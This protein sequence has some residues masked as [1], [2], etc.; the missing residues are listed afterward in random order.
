MYLRT[1]FLRQQRPQQSAHHLVQG[2]SPCFIPSS[3]NNTLMTEGSR[4]QSTA[5]LCFSPFTL[6]VWPL[7]VLHLKSAILQRTQALL[8]PHQFQQMML[9][10]QNQAIYRH[11]LYPSMSLDSSQSNL[12][13]GYGA[14]G[15]SS[16]EGYQ[17]WVPQVSPSHKN[18]FICFCQG[19]CSAT[20]ACC[21]QGDFRRWA[22]PHVCLSG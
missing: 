15:D 17:P 21:N 20:P 9:N 11:L 8:H 4:V 2:T 13:P 14:S 10:Q 18:Q 6:P 16:S 1:S 3:I 19:T 7:E 5:S 22:F 12:H